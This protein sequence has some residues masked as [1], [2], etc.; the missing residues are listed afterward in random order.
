MIVFLAVLLRQSQPPWNVDFRF[1]ERTSF[2][3]AKGDIRRGRVKSPTLGSVAI[4]S[5]PR[6][7]RVPVGPT[8]RPSAS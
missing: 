7:E 4:R 2:R 8:A 3:G 6:S 1:R 5:G